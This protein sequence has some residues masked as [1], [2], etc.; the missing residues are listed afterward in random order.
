MSK[1]NPKT[2]IDDLC[3][4][5]DTSA[6]LCPYRG[7]AIWVGLSV[8]YILSVVLYYGSPLD[9]NEKL[10]DASFLFEMGLAISLFV[11]AVIA[12]SFLRFPDAVQRGHFKLV[13]ITIFAVFAFW[14]LSHAIEEGNIQSF[15]QLKSCSKGL[16]IE[17]IP[18]IALIFL[19]MKGRSTQP[20]SLMMMNVF[21]VTAIGWIALRLTCS[22]YDSMA[23]G[24]I[25][26][27]LPFAIL[28]GLVSFFSRRIFHW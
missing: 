1:I 14:V 22:M 19:T 24:F 16:L 23:Y 25:H 9:F 6:P 12:S 8:A 7:M 26:Y 3:D 2:L 21:A 17:V 10:G 18:F 15:F 11:S 28:G 13:P 5:L 4:D 27:F 20:Y